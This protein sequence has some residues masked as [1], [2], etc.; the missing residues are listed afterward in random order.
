MAEW[1]AKRFWT[2]AQVE[3]AQG[4]WTVS[5]DG[6][7]VKTP[8]KAALIVPTDAIA[9][10]IAAEWDAQEGEIDPLS[11]PFTRT[12]NA[13]IDKVAV[14]R[15]E[16]ADMLAAYG[17]A[18]LLCYRAENPVE[19][20]E[21]Q[22][23][24]WDPYLEWAD[25]TL[26]ARLHPRVGLM[27]ESQDEAALLALSRHTHALSAFELASFHDLVSLTGS[28][29][30]GFAAAQEQGETPDIWAAS[31]LDET[32]QEEQWGVDEEAQVDV[33]IKKTAFFHAKAFF[34]ATR[35]L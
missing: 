7:A 10:A 23:K 18:D 3:E 30:L 29:I 27:H 22:A 33:N 35:A 2:E 17:D 20:V 19:L 12:A 26:G 16:V 11:M 24:T 4:G 8:A 21:R 9:Q 13:A 15:A 31:R 6:R 25:A 28:L 14:Q 5:L 34:D 32:W 1:K